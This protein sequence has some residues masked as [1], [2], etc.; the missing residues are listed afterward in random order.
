VTAE[1]GADHSGSWASGRGG[2]CHMCGPFGSSLGRSGALL[3]TPQTATT[4]AKDIKCVIKEANAAK[5]PTQA[6]VPSYSAVAA[7]TSTP[8]ATL[9]QVAAATP[10]LRVCIQPAQDCIGINTIED[11]RKILNVQTPSRLRY[12]GRQGGHAPEQHS[13]TR[14]PLPLSS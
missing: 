4:P 13:P 9:L 7:R 2:V 11:T 1:A 10:K 5:M 12:S 6:G 14:V 3:K 8:S